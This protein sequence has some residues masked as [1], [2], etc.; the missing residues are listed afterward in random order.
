MARKREIALET[1]EFEPIDTSGLSKILF[2]L[3]LGIT[4][5]LL[6]VTA[7]SAA[8]TGRTLASEK[9]APGQIFDVIA[10]VDS[11]GDTYYYPVVEYYL[12]DSSRRRVELSEGSWPPAY[13]AGQPVTVLYDPNQPSRARIASL[14]GTLGILTLP[15]IT[16]FLGLAFLAATI[17]THWIFKESPT[18][19]PLEDNRVDLQE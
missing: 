17:F 8:I 1:E 12:P 18:I 2:A 9:R 13:E 11:D 15:I 14:S 3:F 5:L 16:G 19:T 6:A 4:V 10:R 7:I